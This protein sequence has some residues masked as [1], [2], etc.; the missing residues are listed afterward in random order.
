M[1]TFLMMISTPTRTKRVTGTPFIGRDTPC[2][3]KLK[4]T[5]ALQPWKAR[6]TTKAR[7]EPTLPLPLSK[8]M[9]CLN[10]PS[11]S[12]L[13]RRRFLLR[14]GI[15]RWVERARAN[16][17]HAHWG[18]VAARFAQFRSLKGSMRDLGHWTMEQR[19]I[20]CRQRQI[21][22][23]LRWR[24]VDALLDMKSVFKWVWHEQFFFVFTS[25]TSNRVTIPWTESLDLP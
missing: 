21:Q 13:D 5:Y 2:E 9:L 11:T 14:R 24:Q 3:R 8:S 23:M 16:R 7:G 12:A 25:N 20:G 17:H 1:L 19:A 10:T 4:E 15:N 18:L 22:A 6:G